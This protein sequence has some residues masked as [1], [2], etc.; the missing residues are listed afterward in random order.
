VFAYQ[1]IELS[2]ILSAGG[3]AVLSGSFA[4]GFLFLQGSHAFLEMG[5]PSVQFCQ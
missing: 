2:T 3:W 1:I 5:D 4:G